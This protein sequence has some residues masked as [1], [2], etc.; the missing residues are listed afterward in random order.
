M[1]RLKVIACDVMKREISYLSSISDCYVDVTYV[2]QGLHNTPD[3][4]RETL[5]E[6]ID[7]TNKGFPYN[8][9]ELRPD[10]D[11]IIL[12][13]GLCSN[14][15]AGLR[16]EK[17]PLVVPRAHD[18]IALLL[19]SKETYDKHFSENHGGVYWYSRGWIE[20]SMQPG[21][22]RYINTLRKYADAY[23]EDNA[24]Y[25]MEMEQGW[26]KEY[27]KAVFINWERL[28]N[29]EYYSN[30]TKKCADYLKWTYL[31]LEGDMTLLANM[32]QGVFNEKDVQMVPPGKK[33]TASYDGDIITA[34]E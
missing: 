2:T 27:H 31:E 8:Q 13:Y 9:Y 7:R 26:F 32:L 3:V 19:G 23:G 15:I 33:I 14:G 11:Y 22:E 1:L 28:G 16:S 6:Q 34:V 10:Y 21:E 18:C 30:Y 17:I 20:C 4:L 5:Q 25:L 29:T 12:I 24:E